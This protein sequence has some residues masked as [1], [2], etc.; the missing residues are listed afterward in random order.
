MKRILLF[1]A[2]ASVPYFRPSLTTNFLTKVVLNRR[3]WREIIQ[4]YNNRIAANRLQLN[5]T[6]ILN[7]L[8]DICNINDNQNFEQIIEIIDK[9]CSYNFDNGDNKTIHNIFRYYGAPNYCDYQEWGIIPFLSRQLISEC[10][11]GLQTSNRHH[12]HDYDELLRLQRDFIQCMTKNDE[13]SIITLNYDDILNESI[14]SL[15]IENGFIN[16]RFSTRSFFDASNTISFP[17]GHI[18]F[19]IDGRGLRNISNLNE[20][21]NIRFNNLFTITLDETQFLL[22]S[23]YSYVFNTS[24]VTGQL[25]ESTFDE[26][27][28][29]AYYQKLAIDIFESQEIVIIGYS[30]QDSHLNRLLRNFLELNDTNIIKIISYI[31]Q[32]INVNNFYGPFSFPFFSNMFRTFGIKSWPYYYNHNL[33][34]VNVTNYGEIYDRIFLY[35][36]GYNNFLHEYN[37]ITQ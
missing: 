33:D 26:N 25:K 34:I 24:I 20:A 18:R 19:I 12:V 6:N 31:I 3:A 14:Q 29:S 23:N 9:I 21:N 11:L 17:H 28:F 15:N 5:E 13:L 7:M 8:L 1:G 4:R 16:E 36:N 10:I 32:D 2:G 35:K 30:F 37:I 22:N 27:P